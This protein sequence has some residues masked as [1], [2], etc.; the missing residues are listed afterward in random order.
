MVWKVVVCEKFQKPHSIKQQG[1]IQL[2]IQNYI[3][4]IYIKHTGL[5][6]KY[7]VNSKAVCS[8]N[9]YKRSVCMYSA[10][11]NDTRSDILIYLFIHSIYANIRTSLSAP[12]ICTIILILIFWINETWMLLSNIIHIVLAYKVKYCI[13]LMFNPFLEIWITF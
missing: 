11:G 7:T 1:H 12:Q 13:D 9:G 10:W 8:F 3:I 2:Y 4:Y 5:H 6:T